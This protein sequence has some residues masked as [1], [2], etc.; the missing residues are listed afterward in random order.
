MVKESYTPVFEEKPLEGPSTT[1]RLIE[2]AERH[3]EDPR[4]WWAA[5]VFWCRN[6]RIEQ[7]DRTYCIMR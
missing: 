2:H 7:T 4:L 1:R 6:K 5:L 3:R